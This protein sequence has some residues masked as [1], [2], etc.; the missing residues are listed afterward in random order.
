[1]TTFSL[2]TK[3]MLSTTCSHE[4]VNHILLKMIVTLFQLGSQLSCCRDKLDERGE[5]GSNLLSSKAKGWRGERL[6]VV[7]WRRQAESTICKVKE[8][9]VSFTF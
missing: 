2:L 6:L 1:M 7:L 5:L 4:R 3:A 9:K 8:E